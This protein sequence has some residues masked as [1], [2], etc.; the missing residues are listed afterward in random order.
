MAATWSWKEAV[1]MSVI[2]CSPSAF[3]R[4]GWQGMLQCFDRSRLRAGRR[5]GSGARS[6]REHEIDNGGVQAHPW[7][8]TSFCRRLGG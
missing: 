6:H 8:R 3:G 2:S 1:D 4:E 5:S 7:S